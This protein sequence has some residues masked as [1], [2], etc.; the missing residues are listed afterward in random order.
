MHAGPALY[1]R[2]KDGKVAPYALWLVAV[3]GFALACA[4]LGPNARAEYDF[5]RGATVVTHIVDRTLLPLPIAE[6]GSSVG[7][8]L[9]AYLVSY[10]VAYAAYEWL[11]RHPSLGLGVIAFA[12]GAACAL[13]VPLLP[14]SDPYAYALYGLEAGPLGLDPYVAQTAGVAGNPWGHVLLGIFPDPSAIARVCNYGP[15][16][17][18]LYGALAEMLWHLP[19]LAFLLAERAL[20]ALAVAATALGL[21]WSQPNASRPERTRSAFGFAFHPLVVFEFVSFAH[22]DVVMLAPLAWA[23]ACWRR[24]RFALAG[25]LCGVAV[26]VRVVAILALAA[27]GVAL[28][29]RGVAALGRGGAGAAAAVAA[30]ALG[31]LWRFGDVSF[32]GPPVFNGYSAPLLALCSLFG[33]PN[34]LSAGVVGG[35]IAGASLGIALL[36]RAARAPSLRALVWLPLAALVATP[37][38]FPH[39][40]AWFV[41]MRSLT[42]DRRVLRVARALSIS[43]PLSYVVHID[44]FP[45][46]GAPVVVQVAILAA[47]WLPVLIALVPEQ[48]RAR[49][50]AG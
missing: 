12:G 9:A 47:V 35:A 34:A 7:P 2:V 49:L 15:G 33:L 23:Y 45:A 26:C 10:F 27:L 36:Y 42:Q 37:S 16:F 48:A 1:A 43:A 29:R 24:E 41:S 6:N 32:G 30:L 22:G 31:S 17:A 13:A 28:W 5:F 38:F 21:W 11:L 18:L 25:A 44:P 14:T 4:A 50:A 19:L 3:G 46:P 40:A 8:V 39:Y 20:G